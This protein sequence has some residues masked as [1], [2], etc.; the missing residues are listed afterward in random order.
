M[1]S[2][3]QRLVLQSCLVSANGVFSEPLSWAGPYFGAG[4]AAASLLGLRASGGLLMGR[5][6]YEI[7]SSQWPAASGDYADYINEMPKYVFSSTLR[8]PSWNNT[9]VIDGDVV[10]GVR[11]LKSIPG[12]DLIVYGHGRFG[13]T[14]CDAGLVDQLTLNLVPVFVAAGD[15]LFQ[16]EGR[17]RTWQFVSA[18]PGADPGLATITYQLD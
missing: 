4:S 14:I 16:P 18:G 12:K 8:D 11:E 3:S 15:T 17:G 13:Q 5:R 10:E 1:T 7:F 6:P 9:T 2:T